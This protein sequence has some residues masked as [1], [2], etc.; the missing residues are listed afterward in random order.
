[1]ETH[2]RQVQCPRLFQ[3]GMP[4]P[5]RSLHS[6]HRRG[7]TLVEILIALTMTLIVLF[8]MAQAFQ[9][10]SQEIADGRAVLEMSSRL[11]N[12]QQLMRLDLASR[13]VQD[14]RPYTDR[15]PNGY[16]EYVDG[17]RT[18]AEDVGSSDGYLGD[19]DDLIAMTCRKIEGSYR[20]RFNNDTLESTYAE[21]VW[22]ADFNDSNGNSAVDFNEGVTLYR[23]VLL[24]RPDRNVNVISG[25][26]AIQS[27]PN[28][29]V[30]FQEFMVN[31]DLSVRWVDTD[32]PTDGIGNIIIANSVEDLALRQNRF[33]HSLETSVYPFEVDVDELFDFRMGV[34][35]NPGDGSFDP[36]YTGDDI[37]LT[38]VAAFDVRIYSPDAKAELRDLDS[39]GV[40]EMLIST[41]DVDYVA[42]S[43]E[44]YGGF[45]DLGKDPDGMGILFSRDHAQFTSGHTEPSKFT[46]G[47]EP[48][49]Y[50]TWS[51]AYEIGNEGTN[52]IDDDGDNGVDDPFEWETG[53]PYPYPV[54]GMQVVFRIIEKDSRQVRQSTVVHNFTR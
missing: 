13:T 18:D 36:Q 20:G 42:G 2:L 11:R 7:L 14:V 21:V 24:I 31:N 49:T 54:R 15:T 37:L 23:R 46:N 30:D 51:P 17:P 38:D 53:P 44:A 9:Y 47:N 22:Y 6:P 29:F 8:A 28:G 39:N 52:G 34:D 1:M 32:T 3:S 45:V 41:T 43:G 48:H 40:G 33:A 27:T 16:F 12:A 5:R 10:A 26:N 25:F 35:S 50:C 4:M 19:F